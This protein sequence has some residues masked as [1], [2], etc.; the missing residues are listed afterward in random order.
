MA[1][2]EA[3]VAAYERWLDVGRQYQLPA[4][5]LSN[6]EIREMLP[7]AEGSWPGALYNATDG[8]AEPAKV[9]PAFAE[10]ARRLGASIV[11][12]CAVDSIERTGGTVTGVL[13]EQGPVRATTVV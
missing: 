8:Q 7:G 13:T 3:G 12:G 4:R 10:A 5:V 6:R 2:T 9:A 11:T 1:G